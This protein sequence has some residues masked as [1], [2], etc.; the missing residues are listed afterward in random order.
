MKERNL[1][2]YQ[3]K[4]KIDKIFDEELTLLYGL[5]LRYVPIKIA[6]PE[7]DIQDEDI[8]LNR[9]VFNKYPL[10]KKETWNGHHFYCILAFIFFFFLYISIFN[11]FT[12]VFQCLMISSKKA[13]S[14]VFVPFSPYNNCS[15]ENCSESNNFP[16]KLQQNDGTQ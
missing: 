16:W 13:C 9:R 14:F 1:C 15:Q 10:G 3:E 12:F 7:Y 6:I 5:I 8:S 2:K 4:K 11:T